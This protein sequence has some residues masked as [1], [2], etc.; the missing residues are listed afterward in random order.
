MPEAYCP[1]CHTL[2]PVRRRWTTVGHLHVWATLALGLLAWWPALLWLPI[3][4]GIS[5]G[6]APHRCAVCGERR[7]ISPRQKL[8]DLEARAA[9][10]A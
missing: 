3:A 9:R 8:A 1:T 4:A 2:R 6:T 10:R 7:L 5:A